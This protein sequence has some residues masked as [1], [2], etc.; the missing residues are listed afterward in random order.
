VTKIDTD[1]VIVQ[2]RPLNQYGFLAIVLPEET[3]TITLHLAPTSPGTH[4]SQHALLIQKQSGLP[5]TPYTLQLPQLQTS[6]VLEQD[7]LITW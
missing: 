1:Q 3:A 7:R 4:L 5:P 2:N 6:F